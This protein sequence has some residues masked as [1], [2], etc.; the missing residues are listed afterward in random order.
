MH[1]SVKQSLFVNIIFVEVYITFCKIL[2]TIDTLHKYINIKENIK[3]TNSYKC[4]IIYLLHTS[5]NTDLIS[6]QIVEILT[7]IRQVS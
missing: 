5:Y 6:K 3:D 1:M 4:I 2:R 7:E